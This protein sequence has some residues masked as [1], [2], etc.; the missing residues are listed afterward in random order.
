MPKLTQAA[1]LYFGPALN[2]QDFVC[3]GCALFVE[4]TSDCA[5]LTPTHVSRVY[6]SCELWIPGPPQAGLPLMRRLSREAAGYDSRGPFTCGRCAYFE[7]PHACA[8]VEGV[9]DAKG[10]CNL[11][12]K[13]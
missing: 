6:D 12:D 8:K 2:R 10:C 4:K 9:V 3:G 13:H 1:A 5:I 11:W 7:G